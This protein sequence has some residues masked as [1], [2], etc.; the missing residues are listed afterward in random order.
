[1]ALDDDGRT[2]S[3]GRCGVTTG[4]REGEREVGRAEHG[5]RA[6]RMV[7]AAKICT[8]QGCAVGHGGVDRGVKPV[9]ES[10][11]AGEQ[12]QLADGAATLAFQT[13]ARQAG[14]GH[15]G[16]DQQ[17]ADGDDIVRNGLQEGSA[18]IGCQGREAVERG[19][20]QLAGFFDFGGHGAG[21]GRR[22]DGVESLSALTLVCADEDG[23][24]EHG[25]LLKFSQIRSASFP[26]INRGPMLTVGLDTDL[27]RGPVN[28]CRAAGPWSGQ[29]ADIFPRLRGSRRYP[30]GQRPNAGFPARAFA[31]RDI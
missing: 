28:D 4:N 6:D 30:S 17:V 27:R 29:C 25:I 2:G 22:V 18:G 10:D 15:G 26:G 21:E 9:T 31:K 24:V 14:F 3:E 7:D 23:S 16:F 5:D 8:G 19:V 20:G 1:M 11:I 13:G 12:T